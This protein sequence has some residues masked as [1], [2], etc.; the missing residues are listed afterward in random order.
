MSFPFLFFLF[1]VLV[2]FKGSNMGVVNIDSDGCAIMLWPA[3][4]PAPVSFK[5]ACAVLCP[6]RL[7]IT[8]L[9]LPPNMK[10]YWYE[11]TK[12][13][14]MGSNKIVIGNRVRNVVL[15]NADPTFEVGPQIMSLLFLN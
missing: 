2:S 12:V 11:A 7:V 8:F 13:T 6:S 14:G 10:N 15:G 5:V 4:A 3:L 9:L 1:F